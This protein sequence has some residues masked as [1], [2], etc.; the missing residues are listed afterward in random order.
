MIV[1]LSGYA[2]SGKDT[3]ARILVEEHGFVRV[4][5]ADAL[6][7]MLYA[8]NPLCETNDGRTVHVKSIVDSRGWDE[9]KVLSAGDDGVRGLL[10]R[11][12]TEAGRQ[13]LGESVWVDAAASK[14]AGVSN[15]VVTDVR[16]PN[17]YEA[18][19]R[20]RG[21]VLRVVRPG[22]APVN[23]HPSETALDG[24]TF[25]GTVHNDAGMENLRVIARTLA[26][27]AGPGRS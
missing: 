9:A 1:G 8:L 27:F 18:I 19:Q 10:Q 20:L 26:L 23:A 13:V 3:F 12:G 24:H 11:L 21:I 17:E 15:Y 16:F 7:D 6:R 2:Q 4:A 25:H 14:M 5:F 22:Y